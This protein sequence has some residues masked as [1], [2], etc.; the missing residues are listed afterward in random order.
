MHAVTSTTVPPGDVYIPQNWKPSSPN[1]RIYVGD[2]LVVHGFVVA[3]TKVGEDAMLIAVPEMDR[4]SD[5]RITL[6]YDPEAIK[7][8]MQAETKRL[9][10]SIGMDMTRGRFF[11]TEE[12][13]D[14]YLKHVNGSP[15][16]WQRWG[17]SV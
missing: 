1:S 9:Y 12:D 7:P 15:T 3:V 16:P 2:I 10:D 5:M 14:G 6:Q 11:I 13:L 17:G 8:S 4:Y